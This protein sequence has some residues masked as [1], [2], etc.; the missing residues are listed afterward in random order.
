MPSNTNNAQD[1][2][3]LQTGKA[4][5]QSV[6]SNPSVSTHVD[7]FHIH[8]ELGQPVLR[9]DLNVKKAPENYLIV[10]AI[11]SKLTDATDDHTSS[12]KNSL[13]IPPRSQMQAPALIRDRICSPTCV[14]MVLDHYGLLDDAI[15]LVKDCYDSTNDMYGVWPVNIGAASRRG[16]LAAVECFSQYAEVCALLD[17]G[18][19]LICSIQFTKNSLSHAP[20][21]ETTG[22][23]VVLTAVNSDHVQVYDPAAKTHTAVSRHYSR[24][25]FFDAW[26]NNMG[27]AY[28]LVPFM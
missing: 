27:V 15:H 16:C 2:W 23:L 14:G 28:V 24:S 10:L 11:T 4:D 9:L 3:Q 1:T 18:I 7:Y 20:L 8:K 22:H 5:S 26:I 21:K 12:T 13:D 25:E 19:P 17:Q 6:N